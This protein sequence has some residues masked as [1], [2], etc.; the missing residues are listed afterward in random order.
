M[1]QTF[2]IIFAVLAVASA[3]AVISLRNPVHSAVFL[4]VCFIQV[5]AIFVLLRSPFLAVV[6]IFVYVGAV[7]VLFLFVV[8]MLDIRKATIE[9]FVYGKGKFLAVIAAVVL[10]YEINKVFRRS[11][12]ANQVIS[13]E[14]HLD[15]SVAEIGT[16]LFTDYILPFEVISIVLLVALVGAIVLGKKEIK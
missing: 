3:I 9:R 8:M 16:V 11:S 14:R 2:F 5:A 13:S 4:M 12:L 15:G 1:E 7:M 6:Q 10:L